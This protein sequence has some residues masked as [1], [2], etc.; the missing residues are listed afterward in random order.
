MMILWSGGLYGLNTICRAVLEQAAGAVLGA[1]YSELK[2]AARPLIGMTSLGKSCL[3]YMV[4]LKPALEARGFEVAVFHTT[5]MGGRAL[6]ALA[7]QGRFAAVLDLSLQEISNYVNGSVVHS[8]ANRLEAAGRAGVPQIVAPGAIDMIDLPAWQRLPE[9]YRGRPYHQHN[10]LI[11]SV[12]ATPDE[13]RASARHIAEKLAAASGPTVVVLPLRGIQEW[14]RP[15]QPLRDLPGHEAFVDEMRQR[16]RAPARL[17][18]ID[19]HINDS[20]FSATVLGIF[21]DWVARSVVP[22]GVTAK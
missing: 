8:G 11:G 22:M 18:E 5:G 21:D 14:D 13:R 20:A 3:R 10:R 12:L 1:S 19:A 9:R 16:V 15:G 6:E 4:E 17:V 7:A 2:A